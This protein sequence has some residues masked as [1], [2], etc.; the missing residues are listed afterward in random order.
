MW[1]RESV[2]QCRGCR[3]N[4]WVGKIPWRG[5]W[6]PTSVFLPG[7]SPWTEEPGGLQSIGSQRVRYDWATEHTHI[8]RSVLLKP[9]SFKSQL[10]LF[11][12]R[13]NG[14]RHSSDLRLALPVNTEASSGKAPLLLKLPQAKTHL[15]T[16]PAK[17]ENHF[18]SA[19]CFLLLSVL[20]A[21]GYNLTQK[22]SV[23]TSTDSNMQIPWQART[24]KIICS[25]HRPAHTF[26]SPE[27]YVCVCVFNP[28]H[29][30]NYPIYSFASKHWFLYN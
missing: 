12:W 9:V 4:P 20:A 13:R 29:F 7:E 30:N 11:S 21:L 16:L 2:C 1:L 19:S 25:I 10:Q 26:M 28:E 8:S 27:Q 3:F 22:S 14:H 24:L 6:Q 23:S 15:T 18:S 17:P 5:K